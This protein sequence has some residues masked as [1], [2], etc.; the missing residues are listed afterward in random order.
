MMREKELTQCLAHAALHMVIVYCC[1]RRLGNGACK[2][3]RLFVQQMWIVPCSVP[4]AGAQIQTGPDPG[5]KELTGRNQL[6]LEATA[7][8]RVTS[9]YSEPS[10]LFLKWEGC[11]GRGV[12]GALNRAKAW[13]CHQ[14]V[15]MHILPQVA[16]TRQTLTQPSKPSPNGPFSRQPFPQGQGPPSSDGHLG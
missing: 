12:Q 6:R 4:G 15:T 8:C 9:R 11:E 5:L 3:E 7:G 16:F 2:M 10:G 13:H 1:H 14:L